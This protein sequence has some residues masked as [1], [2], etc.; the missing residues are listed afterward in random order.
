MNW[1]EEAIQG[2]VPKGVHI[3]LYPVHLYRDDSGRV[4]F[5]VGYTSDGVTKATVNVL[6]RRTSSSAYTGGTWRVVQRYEVGDP[7]GHTRETR[8]A[9]VRMY[10]ELFEDRCEQTGIP[11][12]NERR[13]EMKR[14][15]Q[16]PLKERS[17]STGSP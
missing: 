2:P 4:V 9:L 1:I 16:E 3:G 15:Q 8:A 13:K 17:T 10:T 7:R 12:V 6:V 14:W 5:R 11:C